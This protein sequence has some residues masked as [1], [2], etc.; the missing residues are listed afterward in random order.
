MSRDRVCSLVQVGTS[1]GTARTLI[2]STG[3]VSTETVST[4]VSTV[5]EDTIGEIEGRSH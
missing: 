1:V 5:I 4:T 3:M 2:V